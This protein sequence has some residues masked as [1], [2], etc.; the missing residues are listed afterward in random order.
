M[1]GLSRRFSRLHAVD[2]VIVLLTLVLFFFSAFFWYPGSVSPDSMD[3]WDQATTGVYRDHHPTIMAF[4][5]RILES[6]SRGPQNMLFFHLLIFWGGLAILSLQLRKTFGRW[7]CLIPL[8]GVFPPIFGMLG[9]IWKDIGFGSS[10]LMS[11][12]LVFSLRQK[13]HWYK[14][15]CLLFFLTYAIN[16]RHNGI[17][18]CV[19]HTYLLAKSLWQHL[20]WREKGRL[21]LFLMSLLI[22][23][24]S[25]FTYSTIERVF[26]RPEKMQIQQYLFLVD[27]TALGV[28][29]GQDLVPETSKEK[30]YALD[31]IGRKYEEDSRCSDALIYGGFFKG[32][33]D[34]EVITALMHRWW[35]QIRAHPVIYL[36]HR[37][38]YF[39]GLAG[40]NHGACRSY[41]FYWHEQIS[42]PSPAQFFLREKMETVIMSRLDPTYLYRPCFYVV[43]GMMS[44]L[45]LLFV[46]A[47]Q[48]KTLAMTLNLSALFYF[49]PYFFVS[50]CCDFRYAWWLVIATVIASVITALL[51][52]SESMSQY[53]TG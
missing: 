46:P 25:K 17:V 51:T 9:V 28:L 14:V 52:L 43:I 44:M 33:R 34:P 29:T 37:L 41:H 12:A 19:P 5:W 39:R 45:L 50:L 30:T 4:T 8:L 38:R 15:A 7:A 32:N 2:G 35:Q 6:F 18:A 26:L 36:K 47:S 53:K 1:R 27:L 42:T 40:Y 31:E 49:F 21:P 20:R 23:L 48:G 10:L 16:V 22:I 11:T 24:G 13:F 3:S